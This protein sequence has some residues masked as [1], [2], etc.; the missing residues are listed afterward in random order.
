MMAKKVKVL[1]AIDFIRKGWT[2]HNYAVD[3]NGRAC[4]PQA[5][6]AVKWCAYGAIDVAYKEDAKRN[7]ALKALREVIC[8]PAIA[9]WNDKSTKKQVLAAFKEVGI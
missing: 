6:E 2:K 1:K 3:A 9:V 5:P 8:T 4:D 7:Q